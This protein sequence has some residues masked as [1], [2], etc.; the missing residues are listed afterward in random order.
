[1]TGYMQAWPQKMGKLR[2]SG[3]NKKKVE[4]VGP[5]GGYR[6]TGSQVYR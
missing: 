5:G 2:K 1:M 4:R 3:G 6:P